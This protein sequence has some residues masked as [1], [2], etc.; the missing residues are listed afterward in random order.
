MDPADGPCTRE[1]C[2]H[3]AGVAPM[4]ACKCHVCL[5]LI[6]DA[7][8]RGDITKDQYRFWVLFRTDRMDLDSI[9]MECDLRRDED[10]DG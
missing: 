4:E 10:E 7:Y 2:L 8:E 5:P 9:D 6:M 1:P 3:A